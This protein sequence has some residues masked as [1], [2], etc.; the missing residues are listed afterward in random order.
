MI[1]RKT[2]YSFLF[3]LL[4]AGCIKAYTL[5]LISPCDAYLSGQTQAPASLIVNQQGRAYEVPCNQWFL[6]RAG[7]RDFVSSR[8]FSSSSS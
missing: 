5:R 4:L 8:A 6:R 2:L 1:S 3:A 7:C